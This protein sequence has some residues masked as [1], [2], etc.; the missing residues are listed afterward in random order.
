M[1][2]GVYF[3]PEETRHVLPKC[4]PTQRTEAREARRKNWGYSEKL[5]YF[6]FH[7]EKLKKFGTLLKNLPYLKSKPRNLMG[8][9]HMVFFGSTSFI[10][11]IKGP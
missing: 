3:F 10:L 8:R 1:E 5:S 2:V 4:W 7:L 9:L 11:L 6:C